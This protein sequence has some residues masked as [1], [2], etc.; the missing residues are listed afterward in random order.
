M[1]LS[2]NPTFS[3]NIQSTSTSISWGIGTG[4]ITVAA[5]V[6]PAG[7]PSTFAGVTALTD[8]TNNDV[9]PGIFTSSSSTPNAW[10]M[11]F[12]GTK[13]F[14]TALVAGT[15][16]HLCIRRTGTGA[17]QTHGFVNGTQEATT[18]TCTTSV[19]DKSWTI[20]SGRVGGGLPMNGAV[21]EVAI[22]NTDLSDIEITA[23]AN[24]ESPA[25]IRP[26]AL[27][28]YAQLQRDELRDHVM[29]VTFDKTG[30]PSVADHP[31]VI[32]RPISQGFSFLW[33]SGAITGSAAGTASATGTMRAKGALSG[34]ASGSGT[35]SGTL[36]GK[37]ALSGSVAGSGSASGTLFGKGALAGIA[38]GTGSASGTLVADGALAGSAS[39]IGSASGTLIADGRLEGSASGAG[40]AS[41][42]LLGRGALQGSAA[43]E[44]SAS[45]SLVAGAISGSAEGTG[46][47]SGTLRATGALAGSAAGAGDASGTLLADGA[48][49]GSA[50]GSGSAS[51]TARAH[52]VLAG[53]GAGA[54]TASGTLIAIGELECSVVCLS[55]A[56]GT[57]S[58]IV[59]ISGAAVG[60]GTAFGTLRQPVLLGP[61]DKL[62]GGYARTARL[63]GSYDRV[64]KLE[65]SR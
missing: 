43:G 54:A 7:F 14:D 8:G 55:S 27:L 9:Q 42:T 33:P 40:A 35:S 20:G 38:S 16:Y 57:L 30:A 26:D 23:L 63:S 36:L 6:K 62:L 44:G 59:L 3:Q 15:Q 61:V 46:S 50:S 56:T 18:H 1:A 41:G 31:R 24:G 65:G 45:G 37:G 32:Y 4:N 2:F 19:L 49:A 25:M 39:G 51:G 21:A 60:I 5:F 64:A 10:R 13:V 34:S 52:G 29:G 58:A 53:S 11:S 48:L 47:A 17:G 12:D 22:W 28:G